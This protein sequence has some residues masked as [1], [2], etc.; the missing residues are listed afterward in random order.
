ML[1]EKIILANWKMQLSYDKT[2]DLTKRLKKKLKNHKLKNID[3]V[4]C[5]DF[6]AIPELSKILKDTRID[7]GSQNTFWEEK[8]AYTGEVSIE[9]LK[10]FGVKFVMI[11]H[12]ERRQNL[13]ESEKM[14]NKKVKLTLKQGLI[15]VLCVG[16]NLEE[17]I[18]NQKDFVL[19]KQIKSALSG[20]K[21]KDIENLIIAYEPIWSIST[22]KVKQKIET[23]EVEYT[24]RLIKQI[25][26]DSL[27]SEDD[28]LSTKTFEDKIKLIF[29]GSVNAANISSL[30]RQ[31]HVQ[32]VLVG[33]ASLNAKSFTDLI[34]N[35]I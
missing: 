25:V 6:L 14:I 11:G 18:N 22:T 7:L 17:R 30:I 26:I 9:N 8:G 1:S 16:E 20:I 2:L 4:L 33:G 21:I 32:G 12:S 3:I 23:T 19:M 24:N 31:K 28:T 10:H 27:F 13:A 5:P 29:G 34:N 35:I 15:P